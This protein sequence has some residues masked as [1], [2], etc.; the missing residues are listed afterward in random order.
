M[1]RIHGICT[2]TWGLAALHC[3]PENIELRSSP[4]AAA[5]AA[6]APPAPQPASASSP[7]A[8]GLESSGKL[9]PAD[10]L[11]PVVEEEVRGCGKVDFLFVIDNSLSMLDEQSNLARSFPGFIQVVEQVL[12]A[13]DFHIMVVSTSGRRAEAAELVPDASSCEGVQGA[14]RRRG[15]RGVDCGL[16]DGLPYLVSGQPNLTATFS[17]VAQL[18][19][20]ASIIEEP[21]AAVL[22]ATS[23]ELNAP[24]HCN[25]GFRRADAVLVVT[26]ITDAEDERSADG[27]EAWASSLLARVGGNEDALV[28]LGLVGDNNLES[29]LLGGQCGRFDA[30]D[31]PRLRDFVQRA[32]GMLGSVCAPNYAPFFQT[33]VGAIDSACDDF[34]PP[35]IR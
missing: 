11:A 10:Q 32:G 26:L 23:D 3:G 6:P 15:A 16:Q 31:A 22:A 13:T 24:G 21:M 1:S 5:E 9:L 28:V 8:D 27:P 19:T 7:L 33:S 14:G 12:E 4:G 17:C 20:A 30:E 18:G 2:L 35:K 25:A 34:V 29:G